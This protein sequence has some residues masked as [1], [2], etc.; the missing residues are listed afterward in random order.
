MDRARASSSPLHEPIRLLDLGRNP[1]LDHTESL[2][3]EAATIKI[4]CAINRLGATTST[5]QIQRTANRLP[6]CESFLELARANAGQRWRSQERRMN[7]DGQRQVSRGRRGSNERLSSFEWVWLWEDWKLVEPVDTA[8]G[9]QI[10]CVVDFAWAI[11]D[12]M[13]AREGG[14]EGRSQ[15]LIRRSNSGSTWREGT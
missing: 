13:P 2:L 8:R 6:L 12:M 9:S 4:V 7:G 15:A 3:S 14:R 10:V 11:C 5:Q 1:F